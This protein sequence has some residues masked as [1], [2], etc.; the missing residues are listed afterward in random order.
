MLAKGVSKYHQVSLLQ[1]FN[2]LK[3][4]SLS[5]NGFGKFTKNCFYWEFEAT[6]SEFSKK[7]RVLIIYH[8][9]NYSPKVYVLDKDIWKISKSRK[10][11]HLYD[12]QK[13]KLCLY[14][15]NYKEWS[16]KMPLCNTI[17]A[18]S[19][20]WLYFYE[21]WLYSNDWKGGGK[22]PEPKDN[23]ID[24]DPISFKKTVSRDRKK[25]KKDTVSKAINNIYQSRKKAYLDELEK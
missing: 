24:D 17:V 10:I 19:Y 2:N 25:K 7:Y 13:I 1:Q 12:S 11:P 9:D 3:Y 18:W 6:P 20:L 16:S 21:E 14:Y 22:H 15:P 8:I 23:D 5:K 4:C